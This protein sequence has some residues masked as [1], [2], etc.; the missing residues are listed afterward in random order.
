MAPAAWLDRSWHE[1][2][3]GWQK[4]AEAAVANGWEASIGVGEMVF[5]H[6]DT[7]HQFRAFSANDAVARFLEFYAK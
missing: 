2:R 4:I 1:G 7:G 3:T 6:H 5:R